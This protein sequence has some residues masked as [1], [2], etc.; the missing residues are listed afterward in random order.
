MNGTTGPKL[1]EFALGCII[2]FAN[3]GSSFDS[4]EHRSQVYF[5]TTC[6][7]SNF[8]CGHKEQLRKERKR[9][10]KCTFVLSTSALLSLSLS[11]SP[12]LSSLSLAQTVSHSV[13]Y[14]H[15]VEGR[16]NDETTAAY[17]LK[18]E[19]VPVHEEGTG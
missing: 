15:G 4:S 1:N 5:S 9:L 14:N 19:Q 12:S 8:A 7:K 6:T 13:T 16:Q 3:L 2:H 18:N 11:L 10:R 17:E